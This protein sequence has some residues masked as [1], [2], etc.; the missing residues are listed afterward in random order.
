M[1]ALAKIL[2]APLA[3][4]ITALVITASATISNAVAPEPPAPTKKVSRVAVENAVQL[5]IDSATA[6][7]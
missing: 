5:A 1:S 4:T 3:L 6:K 7:R 2:L